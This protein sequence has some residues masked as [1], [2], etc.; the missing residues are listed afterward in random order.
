MTP[1]GFEPATA[2]SDRLQTFALDRSATGI[3]R[4]YDPLEELATEIHAEH[5]RLLG[6]GL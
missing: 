2:A 4:K 1:A 6:L 5:L 3:G